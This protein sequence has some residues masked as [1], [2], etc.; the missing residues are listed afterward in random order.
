MPYKSQ[1]QRGY[2][3]VHEPKLAARWDREYPHQGPLPE[4]VKKE[5]PIKKALK[6]HRTP[7]S[8]Q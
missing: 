8:R 3:H 1:A 4:H 7:R 5:N 2:L 6:S